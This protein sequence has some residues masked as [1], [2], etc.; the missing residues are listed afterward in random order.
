MKVKTTKT[1]R[2]PHKPNCAEC[3]IAYGELKL[4]CDECWEEYDKQMKNQNEE[5][6]CMISGLMLIEI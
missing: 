3:S 5:E 6:K 1:K 4:N 2:P